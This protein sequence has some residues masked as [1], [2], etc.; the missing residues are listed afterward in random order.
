MVGARFSLLEW[1][2][3]DNQGEVARM[4]HLEIEVEMSV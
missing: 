3:K 4:I 1:E 2:I